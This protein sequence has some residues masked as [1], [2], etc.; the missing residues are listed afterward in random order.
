MFET[1]ILRNSVAATCASL[2]IPLIA[3]SPLGRGVLTGKITAPSDIPANSPLRRI[4]KYQG[5]NLDQ[6]LRL[7][8]ALQKLSVDYQPHTLAQLALSW[9]RQHSGR[10]GLPVIIPI[11]GSSKEENV[12]ANAITVELT[13]A[14]LQKIDTILEENKI[15]GDRAYADQRRYLEG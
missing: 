1:S 6:N 10:D 5:E 14:N 15:V 7:I 12:R 9:I 2:S 4:V 13:V 8:H 3:Y 11:S